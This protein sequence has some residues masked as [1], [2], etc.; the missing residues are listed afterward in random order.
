[1]DTGLL[2]APAAIICTVAEYDP[3]DRFAGFADTDSVSGAV[4]EAGESPTQDAP[5][6]AAQESVPPPAFVIEMPCAAGAV[7]PT[8]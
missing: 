8:V 7:P 1:M 6:E 5:D 2:D 3:A 4:P